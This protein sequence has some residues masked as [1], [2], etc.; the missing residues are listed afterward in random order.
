MLEKRKESVAAFNVDEDVR[1]TAGKSLD[2]YL[3]YAPYVVTILGALLVLIMLVGYHYGWQK[4]VDEPVPS[5]PLQAVVVTGVLML[6][7]LLGGAFYIGQSRDKA[8]RWLR[9]V[10]AG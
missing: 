7:S 9:P 10:G 4:R 5:N 6:I 2:N 1:F 3:K 8:F